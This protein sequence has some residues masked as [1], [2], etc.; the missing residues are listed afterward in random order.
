MSFIM[1]RTKQLKIG[2]LFPYSGIFTNLRKDLQQG[3]DIAFHKQDMAP[4]IGAYPAF[5]QSGG[6]KDTEDALK[7]MLHYDEVDLVIGVVSTKV[8]LQLIPLLEDQKTPM[9]LLNLGAD[10]P[11]DRLSSEY[12]F[13]NSLH[14]WKSEWAMGKWSQKKYGGEPSVNLSIYEAGYGLHEAF[15]SGAA[16]SGALTVKM[17]IV[18]NFSPSPDT[19]PLIQYIR[20]QQPTHAH[21]LLSGIEGSQFLQLF[22]D[23][24]LGAATGLTINPFMAEDGS[25]PD[26]AGSLQHHNAMTWSLGLDTP[27]NADFTSRYRSAY[28]GSPNVFAL[29]AYEAGLALAAAADDL[30]GETSGKAWAEALHRSAQLGPRGSIRLSTRPLDTEMPVYIRHLVKDPLTGILSNK[31]LETVT[32]IEWNDL[33]LVA[34]QTYLTGWQNPYLCV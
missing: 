33:M 34:E 14:L 10:I 28:E 31:V 12:L 7:K 26:I 6:L 19:S 32:G 23:Q 4:E 24:D 13:Y 25:I 22:K 11:T 27:G 8:A 30:Q 3:S 20:A 15:K 18:K 17:N 9:I 1:R 16:A 5:I 2:W 29:L 21:A